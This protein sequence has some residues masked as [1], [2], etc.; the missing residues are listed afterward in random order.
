[1]SDVKAA[2]DIDDQLMIANPMYQHL[3]VS[4]KLCEI[5]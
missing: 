2:L 3:R 1:M 4:Q 5:E